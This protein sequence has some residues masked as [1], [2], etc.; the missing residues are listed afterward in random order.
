MTADAQTERAGS[1]VPPRWRRALA[2]TLLLAAGL[3]A[4]GFMLRL[5][6]RA[7]DG[8]LL[9]R[10]VTGHGAKGQALFVLTG[11]AA[12]AVGLPR[13]AVAFAGGYAFGWA[14]GAA[15]AMPAQ[16]AGSAVAFYWARALGRR[17]VERRL[18]GRLT[19]FRTAI[20]LR[21]FWAVLT[22]RL[23]PVGSSLLLNLLAGVAGVPGRAFL[24][25]STLGFLPQ[26]LVFAL[27][28]GGVQ[29]GRGEQ[30]AAGLVLF[31][32]S[33]AI[34]VLILRRHPQQDV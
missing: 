32:V 5:L 11:A 15:L 19:A 29:V 1:G 18:S 28:G 14:G 26:T 33:A 2:K 7:A 23:M 30:A 25:G 13:Q 24:A 20:L 4:A 8:A 27:L 6:P 34:G 31:A 21:P 3:A 10:F 16:L 12:C 9:D 17:W 22:M